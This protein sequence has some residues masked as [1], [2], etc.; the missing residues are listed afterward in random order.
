M[1]PNPNRMVM[2]WILIVLGIEKDSIIMR[3]LLTVSLPLLPICLIGWWVGIL[4]A[5]VIPNG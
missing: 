3:I 1:K 5:E 4:I 2:D